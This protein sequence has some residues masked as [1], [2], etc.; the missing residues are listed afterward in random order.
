M[1]L[2]REACGLNAKSRAFT[3]LVDK[4]ADNYDA[5][6]LSASGATAFRSSTMRLA[7]VAADIPVFVFVA[8]RLA[9]HKAKAH[10]CCVEP[11]KT[12]CA[13]HS[14]TQPVDPQIFHSRQSAPT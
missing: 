4:K 11:I 10:G 7:F 12:M 1:D 9:R 14:Q 8:N 3:T 5:T 13:I 2:L 6:L